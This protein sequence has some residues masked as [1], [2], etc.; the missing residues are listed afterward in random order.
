MEKLATF[1]TLSYRCDGGMMLGYVSLHDG[2]HPFFHLPRLSSGVYL[3][4]DIEVYAR[5]SI[6]SR[7][8]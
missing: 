7:H 6:F 3:T 1:P 4:H 8:E 5:G 2:E